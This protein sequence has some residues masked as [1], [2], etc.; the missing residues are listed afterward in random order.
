MIDMVILFVGA[1]FLGFG[2]ASLWTPHPAVRRWTWLCFLI[3]GVLV[4]GAS[5]ILLARA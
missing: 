4:G 2:G 1:T 3:G 5:V